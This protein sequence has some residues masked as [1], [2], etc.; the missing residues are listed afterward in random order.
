MNIFLSASNHLGRTDGIWRSG[1]EKNVKK[2]DSLSR[3]I[4]VFSSALAC[5]DPRSPLQTTTSL[6]QIKVFLFTTK[7]DGELSKLYTA[8]PGGYFRRP[9][10]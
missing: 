7:S 9:R 4:G 2:T 1:S 8:F 6:Y 3:E 10:R 5:A